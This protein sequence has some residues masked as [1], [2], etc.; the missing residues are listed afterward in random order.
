MSL[1]LFRE[2]IKWTHYV[3]DVRFTCEYL[4]LLQDNTLQALLEHLRGRRCAMNPQKI[5]G[6]GTAMKFWESGKMHVVPEVVFETMQA[7]P[8]PNNIKETQV[9]VRI[10]GV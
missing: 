4:P 1:F 7:Y 8:T 5:Q 3:D 6:P 10:L 2:S 9:F